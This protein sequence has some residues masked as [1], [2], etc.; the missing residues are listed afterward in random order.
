MEKVVVVECLKQ[1]IRVVVAEDG[2]PCE[3]M[4]EYRDEPRAQKGAICVGRV[5][6]L[7]RATQSAFVDIGTG[8]NAILH[9]EKEDRTVRPGALLTVQIQREPPNPDKGPRVTREI[10]LP[11]R[12]CVLLSG[13]SGVGISQ[14]VTD[15]AQRA[16]LSAAAKAAC[17]QGMGIIVRTQAQDASNEALAAEIEELAAQWRAISARAQG[18]TRPGCVQESADAMDTLLRNLLTPDVTRVVCD[19][20]TMARRMAQ[21]APQLTDRIERY[22]GRMPVLDAM[23]LETRLQKALARKVLLKSGASVVIDH[24]EAMTV[25]DVNSGKSVTHG[26]AEQTALCVN[27]EAA[28]EIARQLRLRDIGGIIVVDFIDMASEAHRETLLEAFRTAVSRDRSHVYIGGLSALGLCEMT[29]STLRQE[30]RESMGQRCRLCG[31]GYYKSWRE[32]AYDVLAQMRRRAWHQGEGG[33]YVLGAHPRLIQAVARLKE[34]FPCAA[35]FAQP[36]EE[37]NEESF[38]L[39]QLP[40]GESTAG[41]QQIEIRSGK[42]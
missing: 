40:E 16:R 22:A 7:I 36:R 38:T 28:R 6:S 31:A 42:K 29:R 37:E 25:I 1:R 4:V 30:L 13:K 24:C 9:A 15:E 10:Q 5:A 12:L 26:D 41:W 35:L 34:D 20:E 18:M 21:A 23:Q 33:R 14:K 17:P 32:R 8:K 19:D 11:G 2:V 27:L 39:T 3:Y